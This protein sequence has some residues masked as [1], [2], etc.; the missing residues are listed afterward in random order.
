LLKNVV[1]EIGQAFRATVALCIR[2]AGNDE[3]PGRWSHF[4]CAILQKYAPVCFGLCRPGVAHLSG[5][6]WRP[7]AIG[8]IAWLPTEP[9]FRDRRITERDVVGRKNLPVNRHAAGKTKHIV[10]AGQIT[11]A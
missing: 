11:V 2:A 9:M 10:L 5:R 4:Q 8:D 1:G 7:D 3:Q 6:S